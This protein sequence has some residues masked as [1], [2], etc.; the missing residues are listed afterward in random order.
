MECINVKSKRSPSGAS[1]F[2]D[3]I[4]TNT[5]KEAIMLQSNQSM[6]YTQYKKD[7]LTKSLRE[8]GQLV[9]IIVD[10]ITQ[11]IIDGQ[12]RSELLF[13]LGIEPWIVQKEST[14]W[15]EERKQ[16]VMTQ[17]YSYM[18]IKWMENYE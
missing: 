18:N 14:N 10:S 8:K 2:R 13:E 16:V 1:F 15:V 7:I 6:N 4:F 3:T 5:N 12:L 9:P 17:G 11:N